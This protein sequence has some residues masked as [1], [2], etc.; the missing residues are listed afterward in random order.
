VKLLQNPSQ[1]QAKWAHEYR[2]RICYQKK[3]KLKKK[4]KVTLL[5]R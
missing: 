3:K 4:N 2:K 1:F 5:I